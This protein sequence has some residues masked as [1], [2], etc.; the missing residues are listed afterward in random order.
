MFLII[1]LFL[2]QFFW[3]NKIPEKRAWFFALI[4]GLIF[5]E[6]FFIINLLPTS[7]YV[8]GLILTLVY[9][10][11]KNTSQRYLLNDLVVKRDIVKYLIIN[12]LI[13]AL[14]LGTAQYH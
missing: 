13:L 5:A 10:N 3:I 12:I 8:N 2:F 14:I 4:L 11:I 9:F 1:S 7:F 6:I